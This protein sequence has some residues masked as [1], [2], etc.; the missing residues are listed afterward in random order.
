MFLI[1][2]IFAYFHPVCVIHK[3]PIR[4]SMNVRVAR[5]CFKLIGLE[6]NDLY[7]AVNILF[8]EPITLEI[9]PQIPCSH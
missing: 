3:M 6:L 2:F 1:N 9:P 8:D 7:Q 5:C 4:N